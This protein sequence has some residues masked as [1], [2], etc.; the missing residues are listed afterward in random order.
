LGFKFLEAHKGV[1]AEIGGDETGHLSLLDAYKKAHWFSFKEVTDMRLLPG[2]DRVVVDGVPG[3]MSRLTETKTCRNVLLATSKIAMSGIFNNGLYQNVIIIYRLLE[4][5]GYKPYLLVNEVVE[6]GDLSTGLADIQ[7]LLLEEYL[8]KPF[9]LIACIEIGMSIDPSIRAVL[10]LMGAKIVKLYLGNILNIDIETSIYYKAAQLAHHIVGEADELWVSPHYSAHLEYA[11]E[12]NRVPLSQGKIAP[13][14]W[15]PMILR[16]AGGEIAWRGSS[17]TQH[18]LIFEPNI[19]FQKCALIPFVAAEAYY[20][21]NPGAD[22]CVH[23]FNSDRFQTAKFFKESI[24]KGTL[25]ARDEK[26]VF[27]DRNSVVDLMKKYPSAVILCHQIANEFNYMVLEALHNGFPVIHNASAWAEAGYYYE[28]NSVQAAAGAL[29]NALGGHV[30]VMPVYKSR[31]AGLAWKHSI[32]NP[33]VQ[34]GWETLLLDHDSLEQ[35]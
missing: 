34:R 30:D 19:S 13:Y 10:K 33:D 32:Y 35:V 23:I 24:V 17:G 21:K 18:I 3:F 7:C 5:M 29:K 1:R 15:D 11:C 12:L 14:V 9:P 6:D 31:A 25:L 22:I 20:Q 4:A 26:V 16:E 28:G 8:L 2:I 27:E